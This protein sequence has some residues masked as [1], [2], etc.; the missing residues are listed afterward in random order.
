MENRM[1]EKVLLGRLVPVEEGR[2]R[3]KCVGG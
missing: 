3:R 1:A 2:I